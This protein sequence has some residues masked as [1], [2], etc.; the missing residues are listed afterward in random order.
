MSYRSKKP[1]SDSI[2]FLHDT[3]KEGAINGK[4]A[5][6]LAKEGYNV[7]AVDL[8]GIGETQSDNLYDSWK[9]AAPDWSDY[10][11]GYLLGKSFV[12]MRTQ[13]ILTCLNAITDLEITIMAKGPL[14]IPALHATALY[15]DAALKNLM[16][17]SPIPSWHDVATTP[18]NYQQLMSTV[19]GAL[20]YYDLPDFE[21]LIGPEKITKINQHLPTF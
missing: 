6:D 14:C 4:T 1:N 12:A 17:D 10:F 8:C 2:L 9:E 11:R 16:L 19:H 20:H 7:L 13:D 21:A 15:R 18:N 3:N 5:E